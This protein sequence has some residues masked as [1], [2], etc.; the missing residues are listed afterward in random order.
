MN[1]R[2]IWGI[3]MA[4]D[5]GTLPIDKGYVAIGWHRLGDFAQVAPT[6]EAFKAAYVQT[7]P[8]EKPGKVPV[9]AGVAYRFA[10]EMKPG[11]IVVY[12]SKQ[13]RMVNIGVIE[14]GY[15]YVAN[16]P[17][18]CPNRHKVKWLKHIARTSFSQPALNEI[19]SAIT[20]F[21]VSSNADEFLAALE[22]EAFEVEDIDEASAEL[23]SAQVEETTEDFIIKRLKNNQTPFQFEHFVAHLLKC[24]GYHSR[25]T[26]ASGDGGIDII[27]HRDE[28]GFEPPIIKVQCKQILSTIGR[29]DVQQL[30]GAIESGE[31]GLFVSLGTFSNDAR[32]FER[33]KP[34]LRLIDGSDLVELIYAH[35]SQFEP[36]YQMLLPLKRTY[37]PGPAIGENE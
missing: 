19:G 18:E 31:H 23:V 17:L 30:H 11:D 3:H 25:V 35:Y 5:H 4:R 9:A 6:R 26:Q 12:P 7:Y 32:T 33:T 1:E 20:L 27:A 16:A 8:N 2:T 15:E 36:R 14:G 10:V 24:M 21:K 34:N 37:I 29:P 22:G 13:D 28:L